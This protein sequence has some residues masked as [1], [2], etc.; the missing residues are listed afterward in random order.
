MENIMYFNN[1]TGPSTSVGIPLTQEEAEKRVLAHNISMRYEI[2]EE[3][4]PADKVILD[5]MV[6]PEEERV[7][8]K[9]KGQMLNVGTYK[10]KG[11]S[12]A[13]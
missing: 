13:K 3:V 8:V 11:Q 9:V 12:T 10:T 4:R 7:I 1:G 2:L 5:G 6:K